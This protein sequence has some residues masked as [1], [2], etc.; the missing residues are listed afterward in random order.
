MSEDKTRVLD[1]PR[2]DEEFDDEEYASGPGR[3]IAIGAVVAIVLGAAGYF[4]GHA[5]ANGSGPTT[6]A[7]AVQQAQ[8]GKLACGDAGAA[9]TPAA[10]GGDA[11]G[12]PPGAG[13]GEFFLRA[14]CDRGANGTGAGTG[15]GGAGGGFGGGRGFGAGGFGL[16]GQVQSIS[17]DTLTLD[18]RQGTIKVKVSSSTK[19]RKNASGS[20]S[21]V[22]PGA[23]VSIAGTGQNNS[24]PATTI[25]ILPTQQ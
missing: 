21:D 14:I 2:D 3:A 15:A 20:L 17:G 1:E 6:L 22:K 12:S 25:T 24:N 7:Q 11:A 8:S 16:A 10:G 13:G 23:T 4:V 5:S 18:G 19:V 9:A